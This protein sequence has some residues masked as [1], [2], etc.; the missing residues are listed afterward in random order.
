[1][2]YLSYYGLE[3]NLFSKGVSSEVSF[4]SKDYKNVMNRL[5]YLKEIKGIGLFT[6]SPGLGKTYTLRCFVDSLNKDLYK[7]IYISPTNLGKFEFFGSIAKQLNINIRSF[8]REE[9]T[10]K[11]KK[12]VKD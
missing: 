2:Q 7:V 10:E 12:Y 6:G 11:G 5:N 3:E 9:K 8:F 4:E 1:M